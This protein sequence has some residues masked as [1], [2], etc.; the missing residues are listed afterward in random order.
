MKVDNGSY[1]RNFCSCEKKAWKKKIT[2]VRDSNPWPLQCRCSTLTNWA[3]KPTGSRSLNWFIINPWRMMMKFWIYEKHIQ[4]FR[5]TLSGKVH[6]T[7]LKG[8]VGGF[9]F[10]FFHRNLKELTGKA[11]EMCLRVLEESNKSRFDSY[12][13]QE[14]CWSYPILPFG[15]VECTFFTTTFLEIAVYVSCGVTHMIF[16]YFITS[17]KTTAVT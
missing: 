10:S 4:L 1:R 3:N 16:T 8:I 6:A 12:S 7:I 13:H 15:I 2:L 5:E 14:Q 17:I 9:E 11:M